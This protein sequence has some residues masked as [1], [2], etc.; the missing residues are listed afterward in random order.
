MVGHSAK[1]TAKLQAGRGSSLEED[2]MEF[3]EEIR[4]EI[5]TLQDQLYRFIFDS[6]LKRGTPVEEAKERAISFVEKEL[7]LVKGT[8]RPTLYLQDGI[9]FED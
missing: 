5:H 7:G 6:I 1:Y 3:V 4:H 9:L 2:N 8:F